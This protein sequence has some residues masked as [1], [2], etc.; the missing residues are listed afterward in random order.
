MGL[1]LSHAV[2]EARGSGRILAEGA[3][4]AR[5]TKMRSAADTNE[6]CSQA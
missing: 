2:G 6:E 5:T 1:R 3:L 4:G